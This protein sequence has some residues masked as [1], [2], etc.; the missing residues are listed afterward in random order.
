MLVAGRLVVN[1]EIRHRETV[2]CAGIHLGAVA[3]SRL[4][5]RLVE[6]RNVLCGHAR[7]LIR[8]AEV[9]LSGDSVDETMRTIGCG[10]GE[11]ATVKTCGACDPLGVMSSRAHHHATAHAV[12]GQPDRYARGYFP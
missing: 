9:Q 2:Q 3:G 1:R 11:P 10:G 7:I 6:P 5:Q 8:M 12:A 4:S